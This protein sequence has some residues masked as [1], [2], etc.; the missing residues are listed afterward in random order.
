MSSLV[1]ISRR[2]TQSLEIASLLVCLLSLSLELL[3]VLSIG[4]GLSRSRESFL[5]NLEMYLLDALF[6]YRV[7]IP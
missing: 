3:P 7:A 2:A 4:R 6:A 5:K 1:S